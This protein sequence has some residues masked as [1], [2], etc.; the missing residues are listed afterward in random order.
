M[1]IN[2]IKVVYKKDHNSFPSQMRTRKP[3]RTGSERSK[4][5]G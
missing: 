4:D 3:T 2:W 5:A 1:Y